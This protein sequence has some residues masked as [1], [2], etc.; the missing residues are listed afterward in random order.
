MRCGYYSLFDIIRHAGLLA[1]NTM[2][3]PYSLKDVIKNC[4]FYPDFDPDLLICKTC[5]RYWICHNLEPP[6]PDG[7]FLID[8][9]A[10]PIG[11]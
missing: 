5:S 10:R 3:E 1:G 9:R 2:R 7:I 6:K 11:K 8:A 4:A